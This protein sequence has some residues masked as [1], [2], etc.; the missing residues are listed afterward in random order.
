MQYQEIGLAGKK[1]I[2]L[3]VAEYAKIYP[4]KSEKIIDPYF[5]LDFYKIKN[6]FSMGNKAQ[7]LIPIFKKTEII[8][9]FAESFTFPPS[10]KDLKIILAN[11]FIDQETVT[12][13]EAVSLY[14]VYSNNFW[15]WII[16][17]LPKVIVLERLGYQGPYITHNSQF[18]N[19]I[20]QLFSIKEDRIFY[21]DKNYIIQNAI[22]S[23]NYN[24]FYTFKHTEILKLL[25]HC[26]LERIKHLPGSSRKYIK[27]I[28]SRLIVNSEEVEAILKNYDFEII[29]P[30]EYSVAKQLSLMTNVDYSVMA[31]GANA[32]LTLT[33]KKCSDFMEFFSS[34]YVVYHTTGIQDMLHLKYHPLVEFRNKPVVLDSYHNAQFCNITVPID[35]FEVLLKNS[36]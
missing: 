11:N 33:Q 6:C 8:K 5:H 24:Y 4:F 26:I 10:L 12:L 2:I 1:Y 9:V 21:T 18:I 31:H 25:R 19:E 3:P 13:D 34:A 27:R 23:P 30:E 17:C 16:E 29:V 36:I 7:L 22:I 28:K 35:Q 14:H 20:F 15:H 32:A